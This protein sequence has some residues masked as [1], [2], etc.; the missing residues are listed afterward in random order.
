MNAKSTGSSSKVSN[1]LNL[2]YG[3]RFCFLSLIRDFFFLF[4]MRRERRDWRDKDLLEKYYQVLP[5]VIPSSILQ[6]EWLT[7]Q[8]LLGVT[9]NI[10]YICRNTV[11][12]RSSKEFWWN[13]WMKWWWEMS[14]EIYCYLFREYLGRDWVYGNLWRELFFSW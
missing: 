8:I 6:L 14:L 10:L 9:L 1:D 13:N 2:F 5:L 11:F 3:L 7:V 4:R 12:Y